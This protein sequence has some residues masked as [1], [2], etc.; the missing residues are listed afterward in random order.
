MKIVNRYVIMEFFKIFLLILTGLTIVYMAVDIFE[1]LDDFT[2]IH[3]DLVTTAKYFLLRLPQ[4]IYY[5]V[6]LSLLFAS[7]L[8]LGLFTKYNEVTAMRSGGLSVLNIASPMLIVTF[9]ISISIFFLNDSVVPAA[10]KKAENIKRRME[11]R[12]EEMFFK[13][14]S[15]WLKSDSH[16]FYNI[17][18]IDPDKKILWGINVYS[19][20][21]D[22][23]IRESI[24]ADKAISVNGQWF[25]QSGIR[26]VFDS[27]N[28]VMKVYTFDQFPI[29][30]PFELKDIRHAVV[31]ASETR[32]SVLRDYIKRIR[33]E[34]YEV[35]RLAV[36]LYAK[37]SF[38]LAGFIMTIIG[39]SLALHIKRFGGIASGMGLCILVSLLYWV[40]FSLSLHM[41]YS[42]YI[43]ALL[44]A[45]LANIIFM[46]VGGYI[47]YRAAKL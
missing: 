35:K 6:P 21:P 31:Q 36:D 5:I 7:F 15:L 16:T 37:T 34:G 2:K 39:V 13:A 1:N 44:S 20:S 10:N 41:G 28:Q 27:D 22:S 25:L 29:P 42:G 38:P 9:L 24:S 17:S 8:N 3:A 47:F 18:F 23:R 4:A 46:G 33:R 45:W 32:F 43:P 11:N 14:D 12:Q 19:L 40:S 30:F 26:R